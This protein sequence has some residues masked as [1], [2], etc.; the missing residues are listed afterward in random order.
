MR[1]YRYTCA[2]EN[3]IIYE[4]RAVENGAPTICNRDGAAIVA[5]SLCCVDFPLPLDDVDVVASGVLDFNNCIVRDLSHTVL[6]DI[7]TN[8][9]DQIDA[10]IG[11]AS[12]H[13]QINDASS[14]STTSTWSAYKTA[15]ELGTKADSTT[16]S[17]HTGNASIHFTEASID[18]R[19]I[20]NVGTNTHAQIDTHISST[21]AHGATGAVVGTTNTQTL[22]NK[23][24]VTPTI[25][26]VLNSGTVTFPVGGGGGE[27]LVGRATTDTLTNKTLVTP[28]ID[29]ILN[30]GTVTLPVGGVGG[31][32]LV[33]RATTDTLTNKT[34]TSTTNNVAS[35][36]LHS[37]TT[38]IDVASATAP[39]S[40]QVLTATSGTA[41]TWQSPAACIKWRGAWTSQNYSLNDAVSYQSGF[42]ICKLPTVSSEVPTNTTY[43]D[44]AVLCSCESANVY[45]SNYQTDE[46]TTTTSTTATSMQTRHTFTSATVPAGTYRVEFM[47]MQRNSS[48]SASVGVRMLVN[49]VV[50]FGGQI[51]ASLTSSTNVNMRD[52]Y[53]GADYV[54]LSS[55]GTLTVQLQYCTYV[56]SGT[57]SMFYSRIALWR[58]A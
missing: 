22:T 41:A 37:A 16:L 35:K 18:H 40:G 51:F 23:T 25:A 48:T 1:T 39:T 6:Q 36:G 17:T 32:T 24:L 58:V 44:V 7:G 19:N 11:N 43:W 14:T 21:I 53:S 5:G 52:C 31:E 12:L 57:S 27:T 30:S 10:H 8:T 47:T 28:T 29:S 26:S 15:S 50:E 3:A 55:S 33:G 13:R 49:S 45:G 46:L 54:T 4:T 9:H 56:G 34:L 20:Q 2:L 38:V 42:Y